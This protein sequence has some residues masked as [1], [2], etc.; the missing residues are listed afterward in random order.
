MRDADSGTLPHSAERRGFFL[1]HR[2]AVSVA[3]FIT[4]PVIRTEHKLRKQ[5]PE[6]RGRQ[7]VPFF[8]GFGVKPVD[9]GSAYS[10]P[11]EAVATR[12]SCDEVK[13]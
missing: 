4:R 11:V 9:S 8:T 5:P 12:G 2:Y 7:T 10:G 1:K 6:E 3:G 13:A